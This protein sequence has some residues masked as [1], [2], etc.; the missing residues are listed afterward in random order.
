MQVVSI[1]ALIPGASSDINTAVV[2]V[3]INMLNYLLTHVAP[4]VSP[5]SD[6]SGTDLQVDGTKLSWGCN[7]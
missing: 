4:E 2:W 1:E 6:Y 5:K 3:L 7:G